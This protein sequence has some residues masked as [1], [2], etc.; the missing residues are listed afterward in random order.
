M[1]ASRTPRHAPQSNDSKL[2]VL[3]LR[4]RI[5]A[6]LVRLRP[7]PYGMRRNIDRLGLHLNAQVLGGSTAEI[8]HR[9]TLLGRPREADPPSLHSRPHEHA[10][11][12]V[13]KPYRPAIGG[14][15]VN[16][17]QRRMIVHRRLVVSL[18]AYSRH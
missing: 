7:Q 5:A 8:F 17:G 1:R 4:P 11:F 10:D 16:G 15:N 12:V 13:D 3:E 2:P 9:V 14:V 6:R 18:I